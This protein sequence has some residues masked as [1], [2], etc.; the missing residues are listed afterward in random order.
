M[1]RK[2]FFDSVRA[3]FGKMKQSQVDGYTKILDEAFVRFTPL[4][5]LAYMLAS[6]WHETAATM[7]P[8]R[9]YGSEA[10]LKSKPY[11]PWVGEG[12]IQVTWEENHRKFGATA[13]GQ[14][15][16]WPKALVALFDGC[17]KG[18]F[19]GKKLSDYIT[20]TATDYRNA[21]RVVNGLDKADLIAGYALTF[22]KAL[23]TAG[24]GALVIEYPPDVNVEV[25]VP[26]PPDVEAIDPLP[27]PKQTWW[28]WLKEIFTR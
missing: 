24:Y 8:V 22:E 11:Y 20:E 13:P 28:G 23:R 9:E 12:L 15:M 27:P 25:A 5:H 10:Y 2:V 14:L 19:T 17:T 26:S 21:R 6:V 1:D 7:Q 18:M 3:S 16:E 4:N